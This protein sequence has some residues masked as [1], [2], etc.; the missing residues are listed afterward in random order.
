[1]QDEVGADEPPGARPVT[2]IVGRIRK[3][4]S[5]RTA[6][7]ACSKGPTSTRIVIKK[8]RGKPRPRHRIRD[9]LFVGRG[10]AVNLPGIA[11]GHRILRLQAR[12]PGHE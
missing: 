3:Y 10:E 4:R 1:M 5:L 11:G 2:R 8:E 9:F 6:A 12:L 7:S